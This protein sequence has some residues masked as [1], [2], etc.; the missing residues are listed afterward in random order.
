MD[1]QV[2]VITPSIAKITTE[3]VSIVKM[4]RQDIRATQLGNSRGVYILCGRGSFYVG[5]GVFQQRLNEHFNNHDKVFSRVYLL[6]VVGDYEALEEFW[7]YLEDIEGYFDRKFTGIG[8]KRMNK[9]STSNISILKKHQHYIDAWES[10]LRIVE[11]GLMEEPVSVQIT[12]AYT[13]ELDDL[14]SD[15]EELYDDFEVGTKADV[16]NDD[17]ERLKEYQEGNVEEH[18]A[19]L[20]LHGY[21][22]DDDT[23]RYV[24][25]VWVISRRVRIEDPLHQLTKQQHEDIARVFDY[26]NIRYGTILRS[27]DIPSKVYRILVESGNLLPSQ[28]DKD[29]F[30][31]KD[32]ILDNIY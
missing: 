20:K 25:N 21:L 18:Y 17:I 10:I 2:K 26:K 14:E 9:D 23:I 3:D 7:H 31:V 24:F 6:T 29:L 11:P 15:S 5:K 4:S 32:T 27:K 13:P 28:E 30:F 22:N 1:I 16:T 19:Y 8:H 12:N